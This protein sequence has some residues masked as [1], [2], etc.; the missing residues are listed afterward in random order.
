[1]PTPLTFERTQIDVL[2]DYKNAQQKLLMDATM[3][4]LRGRTAIVIASDYANDYR[5]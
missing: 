4:F 5:P 1:M 2:N 3:K